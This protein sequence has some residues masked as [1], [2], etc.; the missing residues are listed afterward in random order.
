VEYRGHILFD[1]ITTWTDV[2]TN[3]NNEPLRRNPQVFFETLYEPALNIA[4]RSFPS[5]MNAGYRV[6]NRVK[7]KQRDTIRGTDNK[8]YSWKVRNQPIRPGNPNE[9]LF[10][11]K[12]RPRHNLDGIAMDL[13]HPYK[14]SGLMP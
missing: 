11:C 6:R 13:L 1:F 14:L 9:T 2:R 10:A 5:G 8:H 12:H 3:R 7:G 4:G